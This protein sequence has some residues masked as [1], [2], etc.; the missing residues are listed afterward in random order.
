MRFDLDHARL[1]RHGPISYQDQLADLI[2]REQPRIVVETGTRK[3]V[4]TVLALAAMPE[5]GHLWSCD[6]LYSNQDAA[7]LAIARATGISLPSE[8]WT[9]YGEPS[10]TALPK[11][12]EPWWDLFI[13]DSDH[14]EAN[15]AWELEYAWDMLA[16]GGW[17]VCDDWDTCRHARPH[18]AFKSFVHRHGL[19][20]TT[21]GSAAVVQKTRV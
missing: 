14:G 20:W 13:H 6:P 4:S 12:G 15:M 17:L 16:V 21:M 10:R 2:A 7:T 11:V 3:G 1:H 5:E 19:E 9:F 8:L 18:T